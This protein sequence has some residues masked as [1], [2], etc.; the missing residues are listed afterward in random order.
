MTLGEQV[1]TWVY[2]KLGKNWV[3]RFA[4]FGM[5]AAGGVRAW[6]DFPHEEPL[7]LKLAR[8]FLYIGAALGISSSIGPSSVKPDVDKRGQVV[9]DDPDTA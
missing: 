4:A 8:L 2:R 5:V 7:M 1:D 9:N 6:Y 3:L